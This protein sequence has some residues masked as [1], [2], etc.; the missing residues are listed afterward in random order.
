MGCPHCGARTRRQVSRG[1][2]VCTGLVLGPGPVLGPGGSVQI[3]PVGTPCGHQYIDMSNENVPECHCG[4]LSEG[5]CTR[6]G[7]WVC[8]VHSMVAE[9]SICGNCVH[10]EAKDARQE[11]RE[12]HGRKVRA[13]AEVA[14]PYQ[15]LTRTVAYLLPYAGHIP[16]AIRDSKSSALSSP[17][18]FEALAE[19]LPEMGSDP[20]RWTSSSPP[21][22]ST[23]LAAWFASRAGAA[24]VALDRM[25]VYS[26]RR[27][28]FKEETVVDHTDAWHFSDGA[29]RNGDSALSSWRTY[30]LYV[31][32][33]GRA[34]LDATTVLS[35]GRPRSAGRD[36]V[37]LVHQEYG[38]AVSLWGCAQ[39]AYR[40]VKARAA[41][42]ELGG[43]DDV[44][45][46][47]CVACDV[48]F[49]T[50]HGGRQLLADLVRCGDCVS[51]LQGALDVG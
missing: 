34:A 22:D 30:P 10:R 28:L 17:V 40:L 15:R 8:D 9:E 3:I 45:L 47:R 23:A 24:R 29:T 49:C 42:C 35:R 43:C 50:G 46:G 39:M 18:H 25:P 33:D 27:R 31:L 2:Y 37:Y 41:R 4:F 16:G 26:T 1:V 6:C 48:S 38:C 5:P 32:P 19:I 11:R 7:T 44:A 51:A 14:D 21:W 13:L 20:E 12:A 36:S